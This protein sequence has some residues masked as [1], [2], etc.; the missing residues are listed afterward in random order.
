[1]GRDL[2]TASADGTA[3][4]WHAATG[5]PLG[6][7]MRH[8]DAISALALTRDVLAT[9]GRGRYVRVWHSR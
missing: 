9:G 3:R 1:L 8:P 5:L 7:P 2:L 4:R 6:P